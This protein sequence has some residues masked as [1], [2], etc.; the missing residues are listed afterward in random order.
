[1]SVNEDVFDG[2]WISHSLYQKYF[3][4]MNERLFL[5]SNKKKTKNI[6]LQCNSVLVSANLL[7]PVLIVLQNNK[8]LFI[9]AYFLK[10]FLEKYLAYYIL[11]LLTRAVGFR[12]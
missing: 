12:S 3:L 10:S 8:Q 4:W 6:L 11:Y 9:Y 7:V 5:F 2:A 1:M